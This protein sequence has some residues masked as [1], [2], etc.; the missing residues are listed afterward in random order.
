VSLVFH[1]VLRERT[2]LQALAE[3]DWKGKMLKFAVL[4]NTTGARAS[5]VAFTAA[6]RTRVAT[7]PSTC[8]YTAVW[9]ASISRAST[10]LVSQVDSPARQPGP[11]RRAVLLPASFLL[12]TTAHLTGSGRSTDR[13]FVYHQVI[14]VP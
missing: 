7:T 13:V 3:V 8:T 14:A 11:R 10:L 4:V 5:V 9:T 12:K 2:S 1:G 6:A